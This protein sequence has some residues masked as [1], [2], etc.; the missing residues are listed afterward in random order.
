MTL[1]AGLLVVRGVQLLGTVGNVL[2]LANEADGRLYFVCVNS[3]Q[4]IG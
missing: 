4:F 2:V 1:A 3:V